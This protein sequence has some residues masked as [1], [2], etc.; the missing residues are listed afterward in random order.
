MEQQSYCT[1]GLITIR[2]H[3]Y[4]LPGRKADHRPVLVIIVSAAIADG[5]PDTLFQPQRIQ[6]VVQ[7]TLRIIPLRLCHIHDSHQRMQ[8]L[9]S[10]ILAVIRDTIQLYNFF[11]TDAKIIK[12]LLNHL[13]FLHIL[14]KN[15]ENGRSPSIP[16]LYFC[17]DKK[18]YAT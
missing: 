6:S 13:P 5:A 18:M 11:H 10:A 2:L 1:R 8:H 4:D 14:L 9:K 12:P 3:L 17:T 15:R 7:F 16:S